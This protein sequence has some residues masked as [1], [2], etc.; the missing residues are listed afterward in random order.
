MIKDRLARLYY[1]ETPLDLA[2]F[3]FH[4]LRASQM[5]LEKTVTLFFQASFLH[6]TRFTLTHSNNRTALMEATV[7]PMTI[8]HAIQI[9]E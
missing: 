1:Q 9:S 3:R 6:R 4:F 7:L 5:I 2:T 8:T